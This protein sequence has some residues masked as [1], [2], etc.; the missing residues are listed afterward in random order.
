MSLDFSFFFK[1]F[2]ETVALRA[3]LPPFHRWLARVLRIHDRRVPTIHVVRLHVQTVAKIAERRWM[4]RSDNADV[5]IGCDLFF[6]P[7]SP[8]ATVDNQTAKVIVKDI[9]RTTRSRREYASFGSGLTFV[10]SRPAT[11]T[12][13]LA[14]GWLRILVHRFKRLR[15]SQHDTVGHRI[16]PIASCLSPRICHAT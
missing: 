3:W 9:F 5:G 8:Q 16:S 4:I 15:M 6:H 14:F 2:F 13:I 11:G 10:S 12:G 1:L 7:G